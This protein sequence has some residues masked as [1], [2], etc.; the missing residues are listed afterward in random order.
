MD[1]NYKNPFGAVEVGK[2]IKITIKAQDGVFVNWIKLLIKTD[3]EEEI[4][5]DLEYLLSENGFSTFVCNFK[6]NHVNVYWYKFVA[7]TEMG[8]LQVFDDGNFCPCYYSGKWFQL[9]VY[10]ENFKTPEFI[11]GGIIYHI[12]V[13]RFNRANDAEALFNKPSGRLK[14]WNEEVTIKDEDGVFRANDFYGGNFLG[15]IEK[16]DYLKSLGVTLI[17]LSPIFKSSSNHR[18]D[19]GDYMAIDE[20]LGTESRFKEL[21]VKAGEYGIGIMLDGVF[22]HTGADSIYFNK[23]KHYDSIGAYQGLKSPYFDWYCF[24]KF[25]ENYDCWWGITVTPCVNDQNCSFRQFIFGTNGVLNKWTNMGV[26]GWRLDVVDELNIDFVDQI[27][28]TLKNI[29]P[30]CLMIGEVWED[31]S[32]KVAYSEKRPYLLGNQLDGTMNYPFKDAI[33]NF[34]ADNNAKNFKGKILS[35]FQNYPKQVLDCCMNFLGTHDT[36]RAINSLSDVSVTN[37]T[38]AERL[39]LKLSYS[40]RNFASLRLKLASVIMYTLPGVP[41]IY[42][43][44]EI[45]MEGYDD[46]INRRPFPWGKEDVLLLNHFKKLG[47]IRHSYKESFLEGLEFWEHE[48]LLIYRRGKVLVLINNNNFEVIYPISGGKNILTNQA[49]MRDMV[50][51][52]YNYAILELI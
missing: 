7:D 20:L 19:T 14:M 12:F 47:E 52:P 44:D 51:K 29:D 22:N 49:V 16:L 37:T 39:K 21:I 13:D 28:K 3:N 17:Y 48:N 15:I 9:T 32:T 10:K 31:A 46:P 41:T 27:R 18:Y 24:T 45:G 1:I 23:F 11:K 2:P 25:P 50:L 5:Y 42:Y 30:D 33:L 34:I 43:G 35:I 6:L 8:V 36:V 4:V 40:E 38:K 26:K